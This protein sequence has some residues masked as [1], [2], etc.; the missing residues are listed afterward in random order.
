MR[1]R[2]LGATGL[3]ISEMGLGT[4]G[5]SGEPYG[6]ISAGE[7][8]R[9]M[10][11]AR[12]MG[13]NLFET[14]SSYGLGAV[15]AE[16]GEVLSGDADAIVVTKWGT[17][18]SG[19]FPKKDFSPTFLYRAAESSREKLG[20]AC[21]LIGLLH[22]PSVQCL[23][24]GEVT[25]VLTQLRQ[26]GAI[27]AWGVSAGSREVAEAALSA[28]AQVLSFSYNILQVHPLRELQE[29]LLREKIGVLAH[30]VLFYG[31]LAGRW[32][33][34]K[35]F[36]RTDHRSERWPEGAL[37]TRI[38]QL[39]AVRPAVSGEVKSLRGVA[40]RFVLHNEA[41]SAAILG[42]RTG[43][44][45]DQLVREAGLGPPYLPEGKVSALENRLQ[46]LD[47]PR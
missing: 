45:L 22:N 27:E 35:E 25:E 6:P 2:T 1:R 41:V 17:D 44:Q 30:S 39:D 9:V 12:N 47:V 46:H 8:A 43:A 4:W 31:L 3:E 7:P 10:H 34:S 11:R 23:K 13:I 18:R 19:T 38:R 20:A 15:E 29:R 42:P 37:A 33:P 24:E 32:A 21:R 28:G 16:L 40:L 36:P 26:E 14:A 5:L